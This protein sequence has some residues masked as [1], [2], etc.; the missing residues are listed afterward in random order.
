MSDSNIIPALSYKDAL[1]AIEWLCNA[2]GFEKK[3]VYE[4]DGIVHHAQLTFGNGMIMISSRRDTIYHQQVVRPMDI[5]GMNT[6]GV[7][8]F[9]DDIKQHYEQ[10]C[11]KKV[12]IVVPYE[13]APHGAGYTCRDLEGHLWSFGDFNPWKGE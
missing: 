10:V 13:E 8:L 2:L 9:V 3:V 1:E 11:S 12:E 5:N 6:Q 4:S 7:Y